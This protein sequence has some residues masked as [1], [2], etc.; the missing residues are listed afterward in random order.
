MAFGI[1]AAF[2]APLQAA[3]WTHADVADL[4]T[5][6]A[7]SEREG[8]RPAAYAPDALDQA[9]GQGDPALDQ[10]AERSALALAHDYAEGAAP[11]RVRQNWHIPGHSIDYRAWLEVAKSRHDLAQAFASL[12]PDLPAYRNLRVGLERCRAQDADCTAILASMER[13]R[14]LPRDLG[15]RYLWVN[16]PA[17]RLDVVENGRT[18]V[19][20]RVIVGKPY[21]QTPQ[22]K[23]TVIGVTFNPWWNV[24]CS[25]LPE[26]IGR[27]VRNNPQE[28]ARR[29]YVASRDA[30]GQLVVRQRPG[31]NNAL[32]RVKLEMPNRFNVYIHDTPSRDLFAND[33]RAYS[34]GCIRTDQ[35]L[36]LA[37]G[38]L[39][40]AAMLA[41]EAALT[42]TDTRTILLPQPVSVYVIY[43]TAEPDPDVADGIAVHADIYHRDAMLMPFLSGDTT[44]PQAVMRPIWTS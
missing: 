35:P 12:L 16:V 15:S 3:Q 19:S 29:G 44:L 34:H 36:D 21:R 17:F 37:A 27:L 6:I 14:W 25:I 5:V 40:P 24:P 4:L 26:G 42:T 11:K 30:R 32:G 2:A 23:A 10:I 33:A 20:H 7:G 39:G 22:F 31:P 9:L 43:Q 8:L 18:T 28:A 1:V 41:A 38:L 13:W